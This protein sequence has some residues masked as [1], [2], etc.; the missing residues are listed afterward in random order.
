M[1]IKQDFR[2]ISLDE[3]IDICKERKDNGYRLAQL[4][5]KLERDDSITLIYT[6]IKDAEMVNYK[7]SGLKK[8]VTDELW[9]ALRA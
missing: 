2:S 9:R 6:F 1:A 4:C 7:V 5:P 3:L 8:G